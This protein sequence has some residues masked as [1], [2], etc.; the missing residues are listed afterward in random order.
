MLEKKQII[1]ILFRQGSINYSDAGPFCYRGS[2]GLT[3]FEIMIVMAIIGV[4]ASI[5]TPTLMK[6]RTKAKNALAVSEIRLIEKEI[7]MYQIENLRLPDRLNEVKL[8]NISDPWGNSYQYLKIAQE[9]QVEKENGKDN[10]SGN[11]KGNAKGNDSTNDENPVEDE[12]SKPR[13]DH[14]LVPVNSDF[15][16][17]S[18]GADGKSQA[19]FTAAASFDDIVRIDD[20]RYVG[21]VSEF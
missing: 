19:P 17:Y 3:L 1:S 16:L 21:L 11:G 12:K 6:Y 20:G 7:K 14:F 13:K 9:D 4:L 18:M 2:C 5:A 8:G 15:D 10:G